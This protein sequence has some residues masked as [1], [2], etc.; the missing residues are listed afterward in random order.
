MQLSELTRPLSE[1]TVEHS[2]FF[3]ERSSHKQHQRLDAVALLVCFFASNASVSSARLLAGEFLSSLPRC[4][5]H[6]RG[7]DGDDSGT[8]DDRSQTASLFLSLS[9]C[10]YF[11]EP[12][13]E[14]SRDGSGGGW[15]KLAEAAITT[16][17]KLSLG[18]CLRL[19]THQVHENGE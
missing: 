8:D 9:L 12:Q 18:S 10:R 17:S 14:G 15:E 19:S 6:P 5:V 3:S 4:A 16:L 13:L 1:A 7:S 11:A 2:G